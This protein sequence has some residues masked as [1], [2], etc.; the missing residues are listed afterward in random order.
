[1]TK[2]SCGDHNRGER[3]KKIIQVEVEGILL[4]FAMLCALKPIL[5]NPE[6]RNKVELQH[7]PA[8]FSP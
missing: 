7:S 8:I 4:C 2:L 3:N 5:A 6:G 1:M